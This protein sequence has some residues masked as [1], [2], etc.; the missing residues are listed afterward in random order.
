M[1][2]STSQ[3]FALDLG[4]TRAVLESDSQDLVN[5]FTMTPFYCLQMA[6]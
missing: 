5:A 6:C 3:Q 1:A 4:F 2:A